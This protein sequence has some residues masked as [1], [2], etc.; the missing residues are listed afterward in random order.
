M[1]NTACKTHHSTSQY[2]LRGRMALC[3]QLYTCKCVHVMH[4]PR[5]SSRGAREGSHFGAPLWPSR[6][7][8]P[9]VTLPSRAG[10]ATGSR[11]KIHTLIL[12]MS[13]FGSF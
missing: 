7:R 10:G 6:L 11:L 9:Y 1:Q 4:L 12:Q 5:P 2:R 3:V 13:L 8:Q